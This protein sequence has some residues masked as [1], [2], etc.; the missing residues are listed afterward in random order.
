[1]SIFDEI[2]KKITQ[3]GQ[4][5]ATKTKGLAETVKLNGMI[6]EEE[7]NIENTFYQLGKSYY[8][9]YR[10][11]P[12]QLFINFIDKINAARANIAIYSEQIKQIKGIKSCQNC[13]TDVTYGASFCGSC[14]SSAL[15][16][17][18][19]TD[20]SL[21]CNECGSAISS[22]AAFCRSCGSKVG[23]S[24]GN[25]ISAEPLPVVT[26]SNS[27]ESTIID[28]EKSSETTS[29]AA[30]TESECPQCGNILTAGTVFCLNC[31]HMAKK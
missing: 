23:Q 10:E 12:N 16:A 29:F 2:G 26:E 6:S 27:T 8:Q 11:N 22:N 9:A 5:A 20:N 14:G 15:A 31:G 4:S 17:P 21:V 28:D 24:V 1:M 30:P 13:G 19:A 25:E 3:T 18:I 7:K